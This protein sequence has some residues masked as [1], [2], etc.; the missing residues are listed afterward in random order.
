MNIK[1]KAL[2]VIELM[3]LYS[4]KD[5]GAEVLSAILEDIYSYAHVAIG[6]CKNP[7]KDWVNELD[8]V[9]K[10]LVEEG[11]IKK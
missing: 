4:T 9:Y 5:D 10:K 3:C 7:H 6:N 1:D 2:K 8:I 11:E